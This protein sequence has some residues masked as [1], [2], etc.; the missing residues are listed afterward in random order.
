LLAN[1][2]DAAERDQQMS[3]AKQAIFGVPETKA[4]YVQILFAQAQAAH[5]NGNLA[6]AQAGYKK[7]LKKRPNH[8]DAWHMLGL[9]EL[10]NRNYQATVRSLNRALL[11]DSQ[12]A[13]PHSD[14]GIALKALQ[15][16]DDALPCFDRAIALK[17]DFADAHY[18]RAN[19]LIELGRFA[20]AIAD[21][22]RAIAINPQH[23][24]A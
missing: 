12:S 2:A 7:V 23:V 9:C 11:L 4:S 10:H 5:G 17:P 24:H 13:I 1:Y 6:E 8:F 15:R 19:L 20:E 22:D 14:L 21:F 16:H 18:N 3:L